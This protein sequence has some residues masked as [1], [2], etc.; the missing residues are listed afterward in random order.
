V[1]HPAVLSSFLPPDATTALH[2][3]STVSSPIPTSPRQEALMTQPDHTLRISASAYRQLLSAASDAGLGS[4][5]SNASVHVDIDEVVITIT[6]REVR[7]LTNWLI[8][9]AERHRDAPIT[10]TTVPSTVSSPPSDHSWVREV[11]DH[12]R[13]TPIGYERASIP[14]INVTKKGPQ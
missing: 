6:G 9:V 11:S 13:I 2:R 7:A 8:T 1:V 14:T 10:A 12:Q 3:P 4:L 5:L